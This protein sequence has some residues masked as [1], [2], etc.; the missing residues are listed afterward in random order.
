MANNNVLASS[1]SFKKELVEL[2]VQFVLF[3]FFLN[4]EPEITKMLWLSTL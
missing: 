4:K 1:R 3:F 2:H